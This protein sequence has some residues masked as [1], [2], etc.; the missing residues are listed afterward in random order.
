MPRDATALME[1]IKN[2]GSEE[3]KGLCKKVVGEL[4]GADMHDFAGQFFKELQPD[5]LKN[6]VVG[7]AVN[8]P[9]KEKKEALRETA[10][11]LTPDQQVKVAGEIQQG[12]LPAPGEKTRDRLWLVV[13]SAFAFVLAGSF[14]SIATG[15]FVSPNQGVV[16]K[17]ELVLTMFTS[18]V[19][20][21]AGL[22]VP[23]PTS[24]RQGN[25]K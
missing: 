18:V 8:L 22:F 4:K 7:A 6:A 3:K 12:G 11:Q 16:V 10:R 15:M 9:E 25:G 23:S 20:F 14:I 19:G 17:P 5:A 24:N 2:L 13:V 1:E 21:L